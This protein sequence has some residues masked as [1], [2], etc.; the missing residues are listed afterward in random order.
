MSASSEVE[1]QTQEALR[2]DI[3]VPD[4]CPLCD[5]PLQLRIT[6]ESA[7]G[8]CR[9]CEYLTSPR[10]LPRSEGRY[11]LLFTPASRG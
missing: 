10:I 3:H 4:G 7:W 8:L 1:T 6:P 5:G 9:R 2:V 11:E